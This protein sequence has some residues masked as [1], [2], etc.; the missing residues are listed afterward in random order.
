MDNEIRKQLSLVNHYSFREQHL[1]LCTN[2]CP[3]VNHGITSETDITVY[4]C[5]AHASLGATQ[6]ETEH[7]MGGCFKLLIKYSPNQEEVAAHGLSDSAQTQQRINDKNSTLLFE[8]A[9]RPKR[10][11][12]F[13]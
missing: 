3:S 8:V 1:C 5:H 11:P 4:I 12:P 2:T 9:A 13:L 6:S 10:K 7:S